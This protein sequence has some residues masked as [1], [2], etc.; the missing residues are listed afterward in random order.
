MLAKL[1]AKSMHVCL[2]GKKESS[3]IQPESNLEAPTCL[4]CRLL[5]YSY[6]CF[7]FN[8]PIFS[9]IRQKARFI[10]FKKN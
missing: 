4:N 8:Q 9:S 10:L 1:A 6:I 5:L 7:L 2:T 3:N